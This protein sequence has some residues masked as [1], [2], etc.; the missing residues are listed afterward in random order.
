MDSDSSDIDEFLD[1]TK[2]KTKKEKIAIDIN[3]YDIDV[4]DLLDFTKKKPVKQV[5]DDLVDSDESWVNSDEPWVNSERDY[6]YDELINRFYTKLNDER[7]DN[8]KRLAIKM[9]PPQ[10]D[11]LGT[12][13][14]VWTNFA[15][16]CKTLKRDKD[17]VLTYMLSELGTQGSLDGTE[18]LVIKGRFQSKQIETV[19]R[20]YITEYV[21]C[22][23]CRGGDTTLVKDNRMYFIKCI[24]CG[25]SKSVASL[26]Q[27]QFRAQIGK[28]KM[29]VA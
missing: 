23:T 17:H 7:P 14:V 13:R 4:D 22:G 9:K 27:A 11:R 24:T 10:V 15:D 8:G 3:D 29:V 1:F 5:D 2:K 18:R 28:R 19:I 16:M 25:S 12:K 6:T 26:Q 21:Q 20:H